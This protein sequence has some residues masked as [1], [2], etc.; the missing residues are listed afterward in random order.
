[1]EF[2][3]GKNFLIV[4]IMMAVLVIGVAFT[5]KNIQITPAKNNTL[6]AAVS[7]N[8]LPVNLPP[9]KL[10]NPPKI[11][12][13]VYITGYS[14]G[15]KNYINYLSDFLNGTEINSVVVDIKGSDGYVTYNSALPD[16]Q[17]YRLTD[18]AISNIDAL[19]KFFH[20][21]NIYVIGRIAVFEDP[22]YAKVHPEWAVYN[23]SETTDLSQP[24]LW[25]DKSKLAWMDPA[26]KDVWDYDISLAKDALNNHGFDEINYFV[27]EMSAANINSL[28]GLEIFSTIFLASLGCSS[29]Y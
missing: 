26:S 8:I 9:Q 16:V 19:V 13:A 15:T 18:Y 2:S 17:K 12:K 5:V 1:M 14:A 28:L 7:T 21:K 10:S 11:I 23:K 22:V 24:I 20:D 4:L 25:Q 3:R 27:P 6:T 29:K